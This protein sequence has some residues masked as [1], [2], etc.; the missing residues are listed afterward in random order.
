MGASAAQPAT[1]S[2]WDTCSI[3]TFVRFVSVCA[4]GASIAEPMMS[5]AALS[6]LWFKGDDGKPSTQEELQGLGVAVAVFICYYMISTV[7]FTYLYP[8]KPVLTK[9]KLRHYKLYKERCEFLLAKRK[10]W[11]NEYQQISINKD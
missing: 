8:A 11:Y 5:L 9:A 3:V 6:P 2:P 7:V 4:Q 10:A 1:S